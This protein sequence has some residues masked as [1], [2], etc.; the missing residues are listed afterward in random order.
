MM[1]PAF[2]KAAFALEVGQLSDVVETPFG[3][4]LIKRTE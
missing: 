3:Y 1:V 4:H 2:D